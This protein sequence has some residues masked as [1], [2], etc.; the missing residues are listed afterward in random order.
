[1]ARSKRL[2]DE[3]Q[4]WRNVEEPPGGP[5]AGPVTLTAVECAKVLKRLGS[6]LRVVRP[7]NKA[8]LSVKCPH[9]SSVY[10]WG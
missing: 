8:P 9:V 3:G 6:D 1:M 2:L 4:W 10:A 5:D 7:D